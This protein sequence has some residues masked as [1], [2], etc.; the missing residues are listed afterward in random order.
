M[1][2]FLHAAE[3]EAPTLPFPAGRDRSAPPERRRSFRLM[4]FDA[5]AGAA[6]AI[7]LVSMATLRFRA[8]SSEGCR[9]T[10]ERA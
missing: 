5:I 10:I 1:T 8:A 9:G 3:R 6:A 4:V 7:G 2:A